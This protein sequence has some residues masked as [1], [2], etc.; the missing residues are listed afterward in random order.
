VCLPN[1]VYGGGTGVST[2]TGRAL[3]TGLSSMPTHHLPPTC[4]DES[5][6]TDGP[7]VT[8]PPQPSTGR[9]NIG[10]LRNHL[11]QGSIRRLPYE[12][13][14]LAPTGFDGQ[15]PTPIS[16]SLHSGCPSLRGPSAGRLIGFARPFIAGTR[17]QSRNHRRKTPRRVPTQAASPSGANNTLD[18]HFSFPLL[19]RQWRNG[20]L[21]VNEG[22][23][24]AKRLTHLSVANTGFTPAR[25]TSN[26]AFWCF[27][28]ATTK[29][30]SR[31]WFTGKVFRSALAEGA[32]GGAQRHRRP[33]YFFCECDG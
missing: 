15:P 30:P 32:R 5:A 26:P 20:T 29:R 11:H 6:N 24:R 25:S 8:I 27:L 1:G 14:T 22:P 33:D 31:P 19:I 16:L 18:G 7:S 13:V 17:S 23:Q 3:S 4:R 10:G 28:S 9:P 2:T 21:F 12:A